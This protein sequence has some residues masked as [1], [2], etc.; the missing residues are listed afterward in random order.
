MKPMNI[1]NPPVN[2]MTTPAGI[3]IRSGGFWN[4]G[5]EGQLYAGAIA[6]VPT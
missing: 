2:R 6:W 3:P 5:A 1:M 4:I